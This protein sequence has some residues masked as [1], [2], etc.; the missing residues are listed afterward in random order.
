MNGH[1]VVG[2]DGSRESVAA[3]HWGAREARLR[4]VPL[5]LV[6][7]E[8]WATPLGIPIT[9]EIRRKWADALLR[10]AADEMHRSDPTL[11][12]SIRSIDGRPA[13][14]LAASAQSAAMLVLGSRGL[15]R[16]TGFVLGSVTMSLIHT[17]ERPVVLVRAGEATETPAGQH[18]SDRRLVVGLD[19]GR[20]CDALLAFSFEEASR[21]SC[22]LHAVHGWTPPAV[23]G[24]GAA[25]DPRVR[26]QLDLSAKSRLDDMLRSWRAKYPTVSVTEHVHAG[27]AAWQLLA[28]ASDAELLVVGRR[29]RRSPVGA[30]IGP[31][32]H[33]VIHHAHAPVAVIAHD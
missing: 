13:A 11:T 1:I 21:R 17:T 19:T 9:A 30:H 28:E 10:D 18:R 23:A 27:H 15:G 2:L 14:S 6:H 25:Y 8:E 24:Y 16:L 20:P 4:G 5:H 12:V 33:A 29:I 7:A 22:T 31:V 26:A 32:A 3:S